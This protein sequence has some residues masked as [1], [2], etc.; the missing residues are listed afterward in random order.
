MGGVMWTIVSLIG[1]GVLVLMARVAVAIAFGNV[2]DTQA[3]ANSTADW[4]ERQAK[5]FEARAARW[6]ELHDPESAE[7][8]RTVARGYY[9]R[10]QLFRGDVPS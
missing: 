7:Y 6:E 3:H 8:C 9:R 4:L 10:A 2:D 5:A 1:F